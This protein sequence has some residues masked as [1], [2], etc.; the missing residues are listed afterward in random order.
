MRH[1]PK[2]TRQCWCI[3]LIQRSIVQALSHMTNFLFAIFVR[4][5][6]DYQGLQITQLMSNSDLTRLC[7]FLQR[8]C[9][10]PSNNLQQLDRLSLFTYSC[11]SILSV[12][13]ASLANPIPSNYPRILGR[14][15][16]FSLSFPIAPLPQHPKLPLPTWLHALKPSLINFF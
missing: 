13:P 9:F 14:L 4:L 3:L 12:S 8:P 7:M 2:R 15:L 1:T 10:P 6:H 5:K 16:P 11:L